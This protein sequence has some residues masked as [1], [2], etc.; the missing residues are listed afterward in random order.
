M[1][2]I[3]I[4]DFSRGDL[5]DYL[6]SAGC[7]AYRA[8]QVFRWL[9]ASGVDR[10]DKMTD[11]PE[12][13]RAALEKKFCI[14]RPAALDLKRSFSDGTTKYLMELPDRGTIETVYLPGRDRATVC[15][16]TQV[17]CKFACDFC[18]SAALGFVRNLSQSEII[19]Q[20]MLIKTQNPRANI[21][22]L[23]FMG[24]GE[25]FDNYDNVMRSIKIFN[26]KDAFNI[27]ARRMTVSTCGVIPG[28]KKFSQ[29]GL[30]VELSVSLHSA[31][32]SVRSRLLPVNKR[33]ALDPLME[34]C[35]DYI[36]ATNRIIT[37][38]YVLLKGVNVSVS[39]AGALAE[40]LKGM[41]CR[42]N[43]ISY[44]RAPGKDYAA[45]SEKDELQFIKALK[46]AGLNVTHRRPK[47]DDIDAGCG[48]L[49][50]SVPKKG[51]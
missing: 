33:Y 20:A 36:K 31:D 23:V 13:M 12:N 2:K 14:S 47:G 1:D 35:R 11:L 21:T 7:Q 22:N 3:N 42:V 50:I 41:K 39:D 34:A 38:E 29:E 45:P 16:S 30:Q 40:R 17:G 25:P 8:R 28:I 10:F 9:Y 43:A 27:G 49:R 15:L 26:D 6:K 37:F 46:D 48:Q 19:D 44:N 18:A 51:A 24:V 4:K 5:V 32:D